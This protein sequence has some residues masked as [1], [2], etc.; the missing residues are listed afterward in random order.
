MQI[1]GSASFVRFVVR[2]DIYSEH[3]EQVNSRSTQTPIST[4]GCS[5]QRGTLTSSPLTASR[6][7]ETS[8]VSVCPTE[9]EHL[10]PPPGSSLT[11]EDILAST[12]RVIVTQPDTLTSKQ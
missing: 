8:A 2:A 10:S 5:E 4:K 12:W 7:K 9:H 6:G 1:K 11:L 3:R